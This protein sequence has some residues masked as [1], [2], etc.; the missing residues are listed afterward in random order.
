MMLRRTWLATAVLP[1][2]GLLA[3]AALGGISSDATARAD[4]VKLAQRTSLVSTAAPKKPR[5]TVKLIFVHHSTGENWLADGNGGLGRALKAN[6]YF[7]SDTN[8][9]WGPDAIGDRTDTGHWWLWFRGPQRNTY[10]NAL[11]LEF[12]QH[13]SYSR[14]A[15]PAHSRKNQIIMFKS[16]FPNSQ[17]SGNPSDPPTTGSNPLRGQD[18]GS[19]Y[20][21]VANVKGIYNDILKYFAG[22][23]DKLFVLIVPPPLRDGDTDAAHAANARAVANWLSTKWL[24]HYRY[25]NVAVFDFYNVLT[26]NGGSADV[27]DLGSSE[28]NH[29]RWRNGAIQHTQTEMSDFLAYPSGDSHP[30]RA[31]NIKATKEFV[32]FLN[33]YYHRWAGAR[34]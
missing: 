16:C 13:A 3:L 11:Y 2:G 9:G 33:F 8:Y 30:S 22:H 25:K 19:Q 18:A 29:H 17:I 32:Q 7:V 23:R 5:K 10:L 27:N 14:R 4:G 6:N 31:G 20:M 28:G 24:S 1:L 12:G 26:S 34:A 15:D 21:T